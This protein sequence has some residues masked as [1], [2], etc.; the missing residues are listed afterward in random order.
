VA[1]ILFNAWVRAEGADFDG[2]YTNT[3]IL[4]RYSEIGVW[5]LQGFNVTDAVGNS[6]RLDGSDLSALGFPTRFA[7]GITPSLAIT[8][9]ADAIL[10]SWPAWAS[11][12]RLVSQT[13]LDQSPAWMPVGIEP[14]IIGEDAVVAI[15]QPAGGTF[16]QLSEEP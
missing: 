3:M 7:V 10:M 9:Q 6:I 8:R 1:G 4:P 12:F 13:G 15:T 14:V 5:T 2:V 11:S 16:Y